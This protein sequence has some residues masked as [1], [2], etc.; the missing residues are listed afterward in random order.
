MIV[1]N[2]TPYTQTGQPSHRRTSD[3]F[4]MNSRYVRSHHC[5]A[6]WCYEVCKQ[7]STPK[8]QSDELTSS[9]NKS[10]IMQGATI[11]R[12]TGSEFTGEQPLS[13]PLDQNPQSTVRT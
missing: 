11:W 9:G 1:C 8:R 5:G 12:T 7:N 6:Y 2:E 4:T 10:L 13:L 3:E